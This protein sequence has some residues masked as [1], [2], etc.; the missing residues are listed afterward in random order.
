MRF[1]DR[2][3]ASRKSDRREVPSRRQDMVAV[4]VGCEEALVGVVQ[5]G[6]VLSNKHRRC[7]SHVVR[8]PVF[9]TVESR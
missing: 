6:L 9:G 4:V 1:E 2:F 8:C 7:S 3:C 5:G